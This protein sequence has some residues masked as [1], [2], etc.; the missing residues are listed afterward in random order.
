MELSSLKPAKGSK[1]LKKRL[2]RGESSGIGKTSGH[3]GKGQTARKGA[4]IPARFE[5]GQMPLYRR[6]GKVG[7]YSRIGNLGLNSYTTVNLDTLEQFDAGST[8]DFQALCEKGINFSSKKKAGVKVLGRGNLTKK[9]TVKVN[10]ISESAK[11]K[12]ES[13]GGTVQII[14]NESIGKE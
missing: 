12:I 6:V 5:G 13:L 11:K 8:V 9:I 2:G 4:G 1:K 7:F 10:A 3:G 14:G